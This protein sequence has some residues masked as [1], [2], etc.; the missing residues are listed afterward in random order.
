MASSCSFAI[1]IN[2]ETL[3]QNR[4]QLHKLL[5][6]RALMT[7]LWRLVFVVCDP[8]GVLKR[9]RLWDVP[10]Q[11]QPAD[12]LI[13]FERR[14]FEAGETPWFTASCFYKYRHTPGTRLQ[15]CAHKHKER[16]TAGGALRENQLRCSPLF[17]LGWLP[18]SRRTE[19]IWLSVPLSAIIPLG[20]FDW[21]Y[22]PTIG[23]SWTWE[24][25]PDSVHL[26]H[27]LWSN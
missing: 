11:C 1:Y 18:V 14:V 12:S 25:N 27:F 23:W 4:D 6:K 17:N 5:I 7:Q 10:N 24:C 9:K 19:C 16:L 20:C 13:V 26:V 3:T 22:I 21:A 15:S 2:T 8:P